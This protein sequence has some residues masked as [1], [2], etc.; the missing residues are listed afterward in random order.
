MCVIVVWQ[1]TTSTHDEV[2]E[3]TDL[4][5]SQKV[6]LLGCQAAR[7]LGRLLVHHFN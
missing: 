2:A 7:L 3:V 4:A 6:Q 1:Y 5:I